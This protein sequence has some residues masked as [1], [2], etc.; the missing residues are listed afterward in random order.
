MPSYSRRLASIL[1]GPSAVKYG[2]T[3]SNGFRLVLVTWCL[4]APKVWLRAEI[5]STPT[6]GILNIVAH[7][8]Y[9]EVVW[10]YAKGT[11]ALVPDYEAM[12]NRGV[13][14]EHPRVSVCENLGACNTKPTILVVFVGPALPPDPIP[15]S[16][17]LVKDNVAQESCVDFFCGEVP[18]VKPVWLDYFDRYH[19]HKKAY[20]RVAVKR[21]LA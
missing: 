10:I 18:A 12:W 13:I 8:A 4:L 17:F 19:G 1:K 2:Y 15:T 6:N 7:R 21:N 9:Q 14:I 20:Q 3:L 5:E 16:S 11:V